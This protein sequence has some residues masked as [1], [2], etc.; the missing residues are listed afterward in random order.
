MNS[1][2]INY[3]EEVDRLDQEIIEIQTRISSLEQQE[4]ILLDTLNTNKT[5]YNNIKRQYNEAQQRLIDNE[6]QVVTI[7]SPNEPLN[8]T[9]PNTRL[10]LAI[11]FV[12][13]VFLAIFI[14]FIKQFLKGT[15]W[16]EYE[17]K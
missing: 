6:N 2:L 8:A 13:G 14:V 4:T 12:L 16:S 7:A 5:N 15:D 3:K 10:N 17:N 9:S 11:A 1:Q